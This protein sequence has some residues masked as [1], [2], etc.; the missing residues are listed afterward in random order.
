MN[1]KVIIRDRPWNPNAPHATGIVVCNACF[2]TGF[3]LLRGDTV[4]D[5]RIRWCHICGRISSRR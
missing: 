1:G 3:T 2:R 5:Q 4:H